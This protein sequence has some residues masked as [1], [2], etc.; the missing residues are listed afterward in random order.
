MSMYAVDR[1]E[2]GFAVVEFEGSFLKMDLDKLPDNIREGS[3][4]RKDDGGKFFI[5][6]TE[7]KNR[8]SLL[9]QKQ[10]ALFND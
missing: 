5:D 9:A 6:E 10:N 4:L 3:I 7:T 2:D 1:I 8:K